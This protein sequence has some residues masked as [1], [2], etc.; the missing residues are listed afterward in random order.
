MEIHKEIYYKKNDFLWKIS[1]TKKGTVTKKVRYLGYNLTYDSLCMILTNASISIDINYLWAL[2]RPDPQTLT[3][4]FWRGWTLCALFHKAHQLSHKVWVSFCAL[5]SLG[6]SVNKQAPCTCRF[7][8]FHFWVTFGSLQ[9]SKKK[10]NF[11]KFV[12]GQ[13]EKS[14]F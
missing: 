3:N 5:V 11:A 14:D 2:F 7:L 12:D 4:E 6:Q 13:M 10:K 9:F 1:A 8:A